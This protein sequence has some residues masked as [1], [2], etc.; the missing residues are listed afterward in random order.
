MEPVSITANVISS[1]LEHALP[2]PL[3]TKFVDVFRVEEEILI[4]WTS[5]NYQKIELLGGL[6]LF[7]QGERRTLRI[8]GKPGFI[9]EALKHLSQQGTIRAR[10]SLSK[11]RRRRK[12]SYLLAGSDSLKA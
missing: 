8:R 7:E 9:A 12:R 5:P 2:V 11:T 4:E 3:W 10:K 6:V 1:L